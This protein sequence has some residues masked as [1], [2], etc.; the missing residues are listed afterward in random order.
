MSS[1]FI[2]TAQLNLRSPDN[3]SSIKRNIEQKLR[4][5]NV[6]VNY[7]ISNN[8]VTQI[9]KMNSA[10]K[11]LNASSNAAFGSMIN[12]TRKTSSNLNDLDKSLINV[13]H[14]LAVAIRRFGA[15]TIATSV[16]FGLIHA[17]Q[18]NVKASLE[19]ERELNKISQVTGTSVRSLE[20]LRNEVDS[21]STS[22][23]VSSNGLLSAARTLSQAGLSAQETRKSLKAL[24]L[25]DLAPTFD[26]MSETTEGAIAVFRQFNKEAKDLEGILGSINAVS[27]K[28]AVES[29][30]LITSIRRTGGAAES[31]GSDLHEFFALITSIRATTR[32]S[33]E[34]I[35]TGLRTIS[36]RLQRTSTQ[37]FL[38]DFGINLRVARDEVEKLGKSEGEFVGL[39]EAVRRL[40]IALK[41]ISTTDPRFS[42]ITEE[43]GGFRQITKV[44]PLLKQN[45]LAQQAYNVSLRGTTSLTK[46]ADKA[47]DTLINRLDKLSEKFEKVTRNIISN[48]VFKLLADTFLKIA[49]SILEVTDALKEIIPIISL[50]GSV[51]LFRNVPGVLKGVT[52]NFAAKPIKKRNSGGFIPGV[53]NTDTVPAML[54][55]GEFVIKKSTASKIG[56]QN[57]NKLNSGVQG[58]SAGGGVGNISNSTVASGAII[59]GSFLLEKALEDSNTELKKFLGII[60]QVA[61]QFLIFKQVASFGKRGGPSEKRNLLSKELEDIE[62]RKVTVGTRAKPEPMLKGYDIK[63]LKSNAA[64]QEFNTAAGRFVTDTKEKTDQVNS[65]VNKRNNVARARNK[66]SSTVRDRGSSSPNGSP[67]I[68]TVESQSL[69]DADTLIQ[70]Y[71]QKIKTLSKNNIAPNRRNKETLGFIENR[72]S[73]ERQNRDRLIKKR[74]Q[75]S[76]SLDPEKVKAKLISSK[77]KEITANEKAIKNAEKVNVGLG[78]L[79]SGLV[80]IGSYFKSVSQSTLNEAR[81]SS[82]FSSSQ[83]SSIRNN[84]T[85]GGAAIGAG[86][87][88]LAGAAIGTL[89]FPG[90]GT[91][92]GAGIGLAAGAIGGVIGGVTS[93]NA[94]NSDIQKVEIGQSADKLANTL[95][96]ITKGTISPLAG[97]LNVKTGSKFL[98]DR[99]QTTTDSSVREDLSG[100]IENI[101]NPL[102]SF[103]DKTAQST[104]SLEQFTKIVGIDTI[105]FFTDINKI[106]ISEFNDSISETIKLTQKSLE[107]NKKLISSQIELSERFATQR[108][109]SSSIND[110]EVST[111]KAANRLDLISGGSSQFSFS[112]T[113]LLERTDNIGNEKQFS[114]EVLKIGNVVGPSGAQLSQEAIGISTALNKLPE[115]LSRVANRPSL[116]GNGDIGITIRNELQA[117]KNVPKFAI[118]SIVSNLGKVTEDEGGTQ[119]FINK[120]KLDISSAVSDVSG[121]LSTFQKPLIDFAQSFESQFNSLSGIAE[122]RISLE[123]QL[124]NAQNAAVSNIEARERVL[125]E[126]QNRDVNTSLIRDVDQQKQSNI[127][128]S[129]FGAAND[130]SEIFDR[131][132]TAQDKLFSAEDLLQNATNLTAQEMLNLRKETIQQKLEVGDLTNALGFLSEAS[133]RSAAAQENLSREQRDRGTKFDFA[134]VL[135]FGSNEDKAKLSE[136][137]SLVSFAIEN[138]LDVLNDN[139]KASVESLLNKVGDTKLF[140]GSSGNEVLNKLVEKTLGG[141]N[142]EGVTKANA[143]EQAAQ[144]EVINNFNIAQESLDFLAQIA[145]DSNDSFV[146]NLNDTF[147]SFII[148]LRKSFTES[149]NQNRKEELANAISSKDSLSKSLKFAKS[150]ESVT[151]SDL[152]TVTSNVS[153]LSELDKQIKQFKAFQSVGNIVNSPNED[154]RIDTT[155]LVTNK[156]PGGQ[157]VFEKDNL[158]KYFN[159]IEQRISKD[160]GP[161]EAK[162][163]IS[164]FRTNRL[165]KIALSSQKSSIRNNA[166]AG[167][168][169]IGTGSGLLAGAATGTLIFPGVDTA[170]GDV[171][172]SSL[173]IGISNAYKDL[174]EK[175]QKQK[176]DSEF[177]RSQI[178]SNLGGATPEENDALAKKILGHDKSIK[179]FEKDNGQEFSIVQTKKELSEL[180]IKIQNLTN[181][182]NGSSKPFASGGLVGGK[183]NRDS[184]HARLMP[185]EFVLN[186]K[187]VQE[188]GVS[189]LNR[190]NNSSSNGS[191]GISSS[192]VRPNGQSFQE[193]S[194]NNKSIQDLNRIFQ[195]FG[196]NINRLE[197]AFNNIPK[198]ITMIGKHQVEI[199]ING[200]QVLQNIMPEITNMIENEIK[201]SINLMLKDKF[202]DKG[203]II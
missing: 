185:G 197:S 120:A 191:G 58:F 108:S 203:Q 88:L 67:I 115:I 68:S 47:Q 37:N 83:K 51:A 46:D 81:D 17:F 29:S 112:G 188:A 192:N 84:A 1:D 123:E 34:S 97:S 102:Q 32:E 99:L 187:A 25:S 70:K 45:A 114:D 7:S 179:S 6:P 195:V 38:E 8:S 169:G 20:S 152:R 96:K 40:S 33:A 63:I 30:D 41:D 61:V 174:Q 89:V 15:F 154:D 109:L 106:P 118:D 100:Q 36:T 92:V 60:S 98:K 149:I 172:E 72:V 13:G 186:A 165:S 105:E 10:V 56:I 21:L 79:A 161:Q 103:I 66:I 101:K 143:A 181:A 69:R 91:A 180:N 53:G 159:A 73:T 16:L 62:N 85:A 198:E 127:L 125:S 74:N 199:I 90:V 145:K 201:K 110:L 80:G 144:N 86:S 50:L 4:G 116:N 182:I 9:N 164:D 162:A 119:A 48:T 28:F 189:N 35:A 194:I 44:I 184:I 157:N 121:S 134:K 160:L 166:T 146:Q 136:S 52:S 122:K 23:G 49:D 93:Y 104:S 87:G 126:F 141:R 130:P 133:A 24:A 43:L 12:N 190:I 196:N 64:L 18:S 139:Q 27:S 111:S 71:E 177:S 167:G 168:A 124:V 176:V 142:L 137:I 117:L 59:A 132:V 129:N 131:L 113:K 19:F 153:P 55:P 14:N 65:L 202:P 156:T 158:N 95:D 140:G 31:A 54:T 128:G 148:D 170:I 107:V 173:K 193:I 2:L 171:K 94:A 163:F 11:N 26:N 150:I 22:F 178:V 75:L 78:I 135:A 77:E 5:I 138:G 76:D 175:I 183:G 57:L 3:T 82:F 200:A 42:Q 151:G 147:D 155:S 39:Y